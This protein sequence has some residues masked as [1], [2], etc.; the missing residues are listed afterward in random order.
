MGG[1]INIKIDF[2]RILCPTDLAPETD[3]VLAMR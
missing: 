3:E 2:K 1:N